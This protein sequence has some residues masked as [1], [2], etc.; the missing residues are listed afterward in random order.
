MNDWKVK[1]GTRG[2]VFV[3][4]NHYRTLKIDPLAQLDG[5]APIR[6][7]RAVVKYL[8]AI[9]CLGTGEI[10]NAGFMLDERTPF[11]LLGR[12]GGSSK[13]KAKRSASQSNGR[14]GG[15]PKKAT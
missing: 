6:F 10:Q 2:S 5:D 12:R 11:Q 15:R 9:K 4:F 8:N 13:S 14:L 7:A 3:M 1:R